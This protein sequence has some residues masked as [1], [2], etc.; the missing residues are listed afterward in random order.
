MEDHT[1]CAHHT[2]T[3]KPHVSKHELDDLISA[4]THAEH[5]AQYAKLLDLPRAIIPA[6]PLAIPTLPGGQYLA[7]LFISSRCLGPHAAKTIYPAHK[8]MWDNA[9]CALEVARIPPAAWVKFCTYLWEFTNKSRHMAIPH[10]YVCS[11][12][13]FNRHNMRVFNQ[14][15]LNCPPRIVFPPATRLCWQQS[16]SG[17]IDPDTLLEAEHQAAALQ[18]RIDARVASGE[19]LW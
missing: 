16:L 18:S 5:R 7:K 8:L 2:T 6:A 14:L 1:P 13:V 11:L 9:Y 3:S 15:K 10:T 12:K 19:F 4:S 17:C